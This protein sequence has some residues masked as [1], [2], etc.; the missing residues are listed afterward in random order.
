MSTYGIRMTRGGMDAGVMSFDPGKAH[1]WSV[2]PQPPWLRAQSGTWIRMVFSTRAGTRPHYIELTSSQG[3]VARLPDMPYEV[4]KTMKGTILDA[5][6]WGMFAGP[7]GE[8]DALISSAPAPRSFQIREVGGASIAGLFVMQVDLLTFEIKDVESGESK[9]YGFTGVGLTNPGP[10]SLPPVMP[11][12][13]FS[14]PWNDFNAPGWFTVTDFEGKAVLTSATLAVGSSISKNSF[15]FAPRENT[16]DEFW[17][18]S[19]NLQTGRS[20]AIPSVS[21]VPGSLSLPP[22]RHNVRFRGL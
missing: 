20:L 14:G 16:N 18:D 22:P 7:S 3:S 19:L 2:F 21:R 5:G 1:F 13:D 15:S 17:V 8:F 11:G 12:V 4:G 10:K 6:L 9:I